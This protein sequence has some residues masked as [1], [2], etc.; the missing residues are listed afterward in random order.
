MV[1]GGRQIISKTFSNAM[2]ARRAQHARSARAAPGSRR[3]VTSIEHLK[4]GVKGA[5]MEVFFSW[6]LT[7][8]PPLVTKTVKLLVFRP[9]LIFTLRPLINRRGGGVEVSNRVRQICSIMCQLLFLTKPA[10]W[11]D[12]LLSFQ[13]GTR[14][15]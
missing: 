10:A 14:L 7:H 11:S 2:K 6:K 8:P 4:C 12:T 9:L 5:C 3:A 1:R 13:L 15:W